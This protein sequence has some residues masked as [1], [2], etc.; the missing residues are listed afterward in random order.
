MKAR[1]LK[2]A[3][4][5]ALA[6]MLIVVLPAMAA[7]V[8]PTIGGVRWFPGGGAGAECAQVGQYMYS[9]KIDNWLD[10]MDGEYIASFMDSHTNAITI[11]NSNAYNFDWSA[12][13]SIGAV[14]VKASTTALV[15][16]YSPQVLGDTNLYSPVNLKNKKPYAISHVTFCWNPDENMCYQKETAWADGTRYVDKGSWAT[17]TPFEGMPKTVTLYAGQTMEAGTV[18][19]SEPI[20]GYVTISIQLAEGWSFAYMDE[21]G[22]VWNQSLHIEGYNTEPTAKNPAPGQFTYKYF[23][24]G[25]YYSTT[26]PAFT[27]AYGVHA[28]VE[29]QVACP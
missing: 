6:L 25:T 29:K 27:Y 9:Y 18:T 8:T 22:T 1:S 4:V 10:Q 14:I 28:V 11:A 20:D 7:S 2:Q 15:Y 21:T 13:S 26:V 23:A 5:I 19:F 24:T 17:Y 3:F 12:T 16:N